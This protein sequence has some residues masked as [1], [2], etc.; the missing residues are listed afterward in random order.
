MVVGLEV[1]DLIHH[2]PLV[3]PAQERFH[4]RLPGFKEEVEISEGDDPREEHGT[5]HPVKVCHVDAEYE[6]EGST[7]ERCISIEILKAYFL[8]I[9]KFS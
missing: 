3:E 9:I 6:E 5:S 1:A 7:P 2:N 8:D 4:E